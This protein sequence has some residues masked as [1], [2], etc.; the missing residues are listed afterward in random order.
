MGTDFARRLARLEEVRRAAM[1]APYAAQIDRHAREVAAAGGPAYPVAR[2]MFEDL[3]LFVD[4]QPEDAAGTVDV[5]PIAAWLVE[6]FG[7]QVDDVVTELMARAGVG[8]GSG[9]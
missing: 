8:S 5:V 1:L 7:G 2:R 4:A 6:R 3:S 9:W